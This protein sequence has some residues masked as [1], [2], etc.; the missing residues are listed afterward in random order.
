MRIMIQPFEHKDGGIG[1]DGDKG[2]YLWGRLAIALGKHYDAY[3][4]YE[5]R[6]EGE[7]WE[8]ILEGLEDNL[9]ELA[10]E[11]LGSEHHITLAPEYI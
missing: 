11:T 9:L 10:N 4:E 2:S 8:G 1:W 7:E 5:D 6:G 3:R